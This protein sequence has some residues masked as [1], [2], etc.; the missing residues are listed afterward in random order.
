M[1]IKNA[2]VPSS[3]YRSFVG[4]PP[5][6]MSVT[7]ETHH[8]DIASA[9][10]ATLFAQSVC[11]GLYVVTVGFTIRYLL[12]TVSSPTR[13]RRPDEIR[14]FFVIIA[15][16]L[17]VNCTFNMALTFV[18]V[19]GAFVDF[20]GEAGDYFSQVSSWINVVKV[21]APKLYAQYN[22][23]TWMSQTASLLAQALIGDTVWVCNML[24]QW[25]KKPT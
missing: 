9:Q 6:S 7:R 13:W 14:W 20:D 23:L 8:L 17:F 3:H 18:R 19:I 10:L 5:L 12:R 22:S 11:Y 2:P 16:A 4:Y 25:S 24:D 15:V 1:E 21:R